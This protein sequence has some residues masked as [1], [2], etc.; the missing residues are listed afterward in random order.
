MIIMQDDVAVD[1]ETVLAD[2]P[3]GHKA[4]LRLWLR[5][6]SCVNL[7]ETQIR[8][9]LR[10]QFR[11]TL[12]RFD[13]LAQLER[14]PDGLTLGEI[15]RRMMVSNGNTTALATSL[16]ADGLVERRVHQTDKRAQLLRLTPLGRAEF[17]RQSAAHE[18]WIATLFAAVPDSD[19][20]ALHALLG[21]MK[22]SVRLDRPE[23]AP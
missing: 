8:R 14:A 22:H 5:M 21:A 13:L 17:E 4:D 6:L 12:P 15:S 16:E 7:I 2:T 3:A 20:A 23:D 1:R 11:T 18:T 19:R 9:R 10:E